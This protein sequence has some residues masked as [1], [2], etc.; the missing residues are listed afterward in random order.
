[1]SEREA[2]YKIPIAT[3]DCDFDEFKDRFTLHASE[4]FGK[5]GKEFE[6]RKA[7]TRDDFL[8]QD[9]VNPILSAPGASKTVRL[10]DQDPDDYKS[11]LSSANREYEKYLNDKQSLCSCLMSCLDKSL[12]SAVTQNSGYANAKLN[13]DIIQLW[14]IVKDCAIGSGA[15]SVYV[16]MTKFL[17]LK[18]EGT[19]FTDF[20]EYVKQF[21]EL[22][23]DV[24]RIGT[25]AEIVKKLMNAKFIGGLNKELFATQ[26]R[27]I[28]G[29]A[30]WPEY[31]TLQEE[32]ARYV[33]ASKG[34]ANLGVLKKDNPDGIQANLGRVN[35]GE[36]KGSCFNCGGRL[37]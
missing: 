26:M 20:T 33:N 27:A 4:H 24:E 25:A 30:D 37:N 8:G 34:M 22:I 6:L 16:T 10:K 7:F 29:S 5:A 36:F 2:K 35:G 19:S 28:L 17:N 12:R 18:M 21:N 13:D 9:K 11:R 23:A 32:L 15:H 14:D 3:L 1:M 31:K